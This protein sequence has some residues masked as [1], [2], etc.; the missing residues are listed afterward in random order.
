[1]AHDQSAGIPLIQ[2]KKLSK[3][4]RPALEVLGRSNDTAHVAKVCAEIIASGVNLKHY[5]YEF[6]TGLPD[7][8][9]P[10][11]KQLDWMDALLL[12]ARK[13]A[14][15]PPPPPPPPPRPA[16]A[17]RP[18]KPKPK[19]KQSPVEAEADESPPAPPP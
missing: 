3:Q 11:E 12:R 19:P 7:Y 13:F 1:M 9:R 2:S 14:A 5:E 4:T 10:T 6:I 16:K 15:R 18:P 8:R 17:K